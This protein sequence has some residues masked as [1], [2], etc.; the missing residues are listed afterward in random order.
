MT[1]LV[2]CFSP[3]AF[4]AGSINKL[5][6]LLSLTIRWLCDGYLNQIRPK[7]RPINFAS[8]KLHK[9][10]VYKTITP[11]VQLWAR[12]FPHKCPLPHLSGLQ[13]GFGGKGLFRSAFS[14]WLIDTFYLNHTG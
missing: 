9:Y 13:L 11:A 8:E 5:T 3:S 14:S 7:N 4:A 10:A 12:T 6:H 2:L 1:I